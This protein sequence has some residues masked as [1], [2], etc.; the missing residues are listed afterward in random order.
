MMKLKNVL[1][2]CILPLCLVSCGKK[3]IYK[4]EVREV[5]IDSV[6]SKG[7]YGTELSIDLIGTNSLFVADS[8]L[9]ADIQNGSKPY[10]FEIFSFFSSILTLKLLWS[11]SFCREYKYS[12]IVSKP[13]VLIAMNLPSLDKYEDATVAGGQIFVDSSLIERKIQRSDVEAYYIPATKLASDNDLSG[14][15]NMIMIG[16]MIKKSGIIP[17]EN[18]AKT[19]E[20]IV[21]AKKQ[22]LVEAHKKAI[23]LG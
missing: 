19:V 16:F 9:V 15:A 23:E 3:S 6:P 21:P 8:L 2:L 13:D 10:F 17:Y 20:K 4:Y 5:Y 22:H 12:P 11:L 18:V 1:T 14:L 7:I